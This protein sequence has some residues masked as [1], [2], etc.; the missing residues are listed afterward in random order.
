M[1]IAGIDPSS[2]CTGVALTENDKLISTDAWHK[3]KNKSS[4]ECLVDYFT[5]L[6]NWIFANEPDICVVE[7]LSVTRNAEAVRVI[8][9]YQ[10]LSVLVCKLRNKMVIEA[11]VSSARKATLGKGNLSK[12]ESYNIIKKRFPQEDWG[13]I[14]NGGADRADALILALAGLKLAER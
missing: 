9:H 14:D 2:S 11:R 7:F 8:S 3:P 12:Q 1:K 4:P 13:R 10:A 6:Q 5:W